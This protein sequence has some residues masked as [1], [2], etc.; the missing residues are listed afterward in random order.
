MFNTGM[1]GAKVSRCG[2]LPVDFSFSPMNSHQMQSMF[3]SG[4]LLVAVFGFTAC[5]SGD[6]DGSGSAVATTGSGAWR[7][8]ETGFGPLRAGQTVA[9]AAAAAGGAFTAVAGAPAECSY[10][11]WPAAPS[12][13]RV[14]LVHDTVV[15]IEVTGRSAHWRQ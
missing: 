3:R 10:A 13:V 12:G 2:E 9:E 14:M 15:R 7:I 6:T 5:S 11:E 8:T 4:V 1:A